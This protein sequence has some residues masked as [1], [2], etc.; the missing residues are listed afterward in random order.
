MHSL[1][2]FMIIG[3]IREDMKEVINGKKGNLYL[4]LDKCR[5]ILDVKE[6]INGNI[7]LVLGPQ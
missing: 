4:V 3:L 6:D 1:P 7:E 2:I 5:Y